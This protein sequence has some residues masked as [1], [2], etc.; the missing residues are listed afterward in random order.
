LAAHLSLDLLAGRHDETTVGPNPSV[1]RCPDDGALARMPELFE[2]VLTA[3]PL[4]LIANE[5]KSRSFGRR[6]FHQ[7]D[8]SAV[9]EPHVGGAVEAAVAAAGLDE[10]VRGSGQ[11]A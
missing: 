11:P 2:D 10:V 1:L 3:G 4:D 7:E 6:P 5:E 9:A 8:A